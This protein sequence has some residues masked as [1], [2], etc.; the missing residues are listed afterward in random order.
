LSPQL[1]ERLTFFVGGR[2]STEPLFLTKKGKR[3]HPDN[4]VKRQLKPLLNALG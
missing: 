3:L 1:A 4:F 2:N